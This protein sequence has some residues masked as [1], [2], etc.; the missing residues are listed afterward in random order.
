GPAHPDDH[1]A[2]HMNKRH[3]SDVRLDGDLAEEDVR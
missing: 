1:R 3:W 2:W